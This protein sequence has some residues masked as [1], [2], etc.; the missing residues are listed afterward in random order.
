VTAGTAGT[1]EPVFSN[2][3]GVTTTDG[4]VVWSSCGSTTPPEMAQD[5]QRSA[6]VPLGA[7]MIPKPIMGVGNRGSITTP[8]SLNY[9]PTGVPIT[10]YT[11]LS[12]SGDAMP[13]ST[14]MECTGGGLLGGLSPA[15]AGFNTF[16][17]PSGQSLFICVAPGITGGFH[18]TLNETPGARTTDGSVVWQ[19]VGPVALP[20]G[21]VPGLVSARSYFPSGRGQ[22]S[23]QHLICRARAKLRKRARAVQVEFD[24]RF[25]AA[26]NAAIS[27][28]KNAS[29]TD[30]RLPGGSA[31]GKI[32]A[33]K[34]MVD[35]DRGG[36]TAHVTIGCSIG[37]AGSVTAAPGTETYVTAGYVQPSYQA[38]VGATITV[39]S[40]GSPDVGYTPPVEQP[41]DDGLVF[42]L[43]GAGDV[44][45]ANGWHGTASAI[46]P[47][48]IAG[49]NLQLATA[50]QS[51][52]SQANQ[53]YSVVGPD[54][55]ASGNIP[56]IDWVGINDQVLSSVY[57]SIFQGTGLW[58][59][60]ALKPLTG[61]PYAA[62][63]VIS[64]TPLI[65]PQTI[66]L[67]S[68]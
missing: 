6:P 51:A 46:N 12:V 4:S 47:G 3:G 7:T 16:T 49:Y 14:M 57:Q 48:N 68:P 54:G 9:P 27:C 62:A 36:A 52:T 32:I 67:S 38:M 64:T 44:I 31:A 39:S 40:S 61:G 25:E 35:G 43:S 30:A 55:S 15:Q 17:N 41:V 18:T 42:P 45:L 21:G 66:N 5:W 63:Y 22:Q 26:A 1:V 19:C 58:Y 34:L 2:I 11:I 53:S 65:I 13:G 59:E 60:L 24:P 28:R 8:G 33:Y 56:S 23:L 29:I 50:V 20:I 10:L 37:L